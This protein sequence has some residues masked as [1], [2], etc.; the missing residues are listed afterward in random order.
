M[1]TRKKP[2][3]SVHTY[4]YKVI[5]YKLVDLSSL[6]FISIARKKCTWIPEPQRSTKRR[7]ER[8]KEGEM[9]A[10]E[11]AMIC[12]ELLY[13]ITSGTMSFAPEVQN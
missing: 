7:W 2:H 11:R 5:L 6:E 8:A 10:M 1:I 3:S 4:T 9:R 13:R 12:S